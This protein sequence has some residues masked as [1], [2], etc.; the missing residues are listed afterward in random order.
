M[1]KK[2]LLPIVALALAASS[3]TKHDVIGHNQSKFVDPTLV[4]FSAYAGKSRAESTTAETFKEFQVYSYRGELGTDAPIV[5]SS[6]KPTL[7]M[8]NVKVTKT[9]DTWEAASP[10]PWPSKGTHVQFFA[11]SPAASDASGISYKKDEQSGYKPALNFTAQTDVAK[12]VDLLYAQSG[13]MKAAAT[14]EHNKVE[15]TFTHA[16]TKVKFSAKVQ[17]NQE[18][19]LS[20]LSLHN[21]GSK[22]SFAYTTEESVEGAWNEAVITNEGFAIALSAKAGEGI[23]ETEAIDVTAKD[24]A[25]LV[26]PQKRTKVDVTAPG[27]HLFTENKE[28]SYIKM[29]YSLKNTTAGDWIVGGEGKPVT[30]YI[31][32]DVDF[33]MNQVIN[34]AINFGTGNGG[35]DDGGKPIIDSKNMIQFDTKF[36]DWDAETPID[37][38]P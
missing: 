30:A 17:P 19:Y 28:N 22:G 24:G 35:Y 27:D 33:N 11:F 20:E 5:W 9:G 36:T 23:T 7:S 25:T 2:F 15:L 8:D 12:Q 10:T 31:P 6:D 3:C 13:E 16:L 32:V 29:V 34:Y 14:S 37:P 4:N 21:L 1:N 18:L 26:I 38:T